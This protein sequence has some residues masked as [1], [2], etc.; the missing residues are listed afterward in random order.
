MSRNFARGIQSTARTL[1]SYVSS[2]PSDIVAMNGAQGPDF[3]LATTTI[4]SAIEKADPRITNAQIQ[5]RNDA[6]NVITVGLL[7]ATGTRVATVHIHRDGTFKF[8]ASRWGKEKGIEQNISRA[9]IP[10]HLPSSDDD[11][12]AK[13]SK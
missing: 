1:I 7:T 12:S 8:W 13:G 3:G 9:C 6:Q 11:L 4:L 2:N 5:D 10:G